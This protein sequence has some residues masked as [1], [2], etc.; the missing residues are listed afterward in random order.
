MRRK[1]QLFNFL[2]NLGLLGGLLLE[3]D[4]R[5]NKRH[6]GHGHPAGKRA[7]DSA[8]SGSKNI[9]GKAKRLEA[10]ARRVEIRG[11]RRAR[12]AAVEASKFASRTAADVSKGSKRAAK[13][14]HDIVGQYAPQYAQSASQYAQSA[15]EHAGQLASYAHDHLNSLK[16]S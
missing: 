9:A 3:I 15:S 2:K 14:T 4:S 13:R 11:E 1:Q 5:P 7:A 6:R 8:R 12:Q 16:A 10:R